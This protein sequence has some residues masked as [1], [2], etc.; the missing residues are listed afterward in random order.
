MTPF[1]KPCTALAEG[2]R[3]AACRSAGLC[4]SATLVL[5][6]IASGLLG[7]QPAAAA[8]RESSELAEVFATQ[9]EFT[10][11][12]G[13]AVAVRTVAGTLAIERADLGLRLTLDGRPIDIKNDYLHF[14]AISKHGTQDLVLVASE[15]AGS[16]CSY[17]ELAFLRLTR[18]SSPAIETAREFWY[19]D[20][21][22]ENDAARITYHAHT[23]S[24]PLGLR[25]GEER[26]A[27]IGPQAKLAIDAHAVPIVP[28]SADDCRAAQALL[29]ECAAFSEPCS[30]SASPAVAYDCPDASMAFQRALTDLAD[31]TTG[32]NL[33]RFA[34]ACVTASHSHRAPDPRQVT[35]SICV[36]ADPAQWIAVPT[37]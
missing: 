10:L 13:D 4:V 14:V 29:E 24:I 1:S 3:A 19:A 17:L 6:A 33:P 28:L 11:V 26:T 32:L 36:G 37:Q 30:Q 31:H 21:D 2:A 35:A 5:F 22:L 12:P 8:A 16:A 7:T 9:A 15:C 20:T 34:A 18:G 25:D 27:T 23:W